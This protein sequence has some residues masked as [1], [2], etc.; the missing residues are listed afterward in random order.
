MNVE[1]L[2]RNVSTF[3]RQQAGCRDVA[4]QPLYRIFWKMQF[5]RKQV[6]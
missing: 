5:L 2:R 1:A 3:T 6:V 4:L